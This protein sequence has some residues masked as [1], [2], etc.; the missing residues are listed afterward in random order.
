MTDVHDE[1]R[2]LLAAYVMDAVPAEEIPAIRAHILSCEECFAEAESY[3]EAL[4]GLAASVAPA[5]MPPGFS[6]RVLAAARGPVEA[7]A[8]APRRS[9]R[10]RRALIGGAVALMTLTLA[11]TS[12]SL[13][14]SLDRQH[15]YENALA[16][17]LRD[18]DAL[19]LSGPGG[20]VAVVASSGERAT[21]V[22]LNLGEAPTG[23]DYQLWLMKDGVPTPSETFDATDSII[24]I[25][26]VEDLAGYDGAAITV[27]PDGGS[28][29]PTTEPILS[30]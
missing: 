8:P 2:S 23:S 1:I 22:A 5:P 16:A 9:F 6:E 18:E 28:P 29:Q 7:P 4:T 21:L 14:R 15:R 25:D 27:E 30:S 26:S 10:L 3:A 19:T 17:L 12:V 11:V 13:V 24:I 20:A